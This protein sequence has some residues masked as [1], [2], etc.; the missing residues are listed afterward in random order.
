MIIQIDNESILC[1]SF[2]E[3]KVKMNKI[4]EMVSAEIWISENGE[5][6]E[7]PCLAILINNDEV[8]INYFGEDG[9]NFVTI[10]DEEDDRIISFCE[11]QYDVAGYQVIDKETAIKGICEYFDSQ[12][13]SDGLKW[14]EL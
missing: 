9:S 5:Q 11:G 3:F 7:L 2:D 10:G 14:E 13:M 4:F 1:N 8:V 12:S 6:D